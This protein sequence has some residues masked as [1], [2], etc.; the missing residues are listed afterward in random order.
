MICDRCKCKISKDDKLFAVT[1]KLQTNIEG[2]S[3]SAIDVYR[4]HVEQEATLCAGCA[5]FMA[6]N[7]KS[8]RGDGDAA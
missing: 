1:M 6:G 3:G 2:Y 4:D 7:I 8:W 5:M